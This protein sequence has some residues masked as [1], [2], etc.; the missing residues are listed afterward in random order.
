M[1]FRR[2]ARRAVVWGAL[3]ILLLVGARYAYA[4]F[5]KFGLSSRLAWNSQAPRGVS[6][7]AGHCWLT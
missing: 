3:L 5:G 6:A 4:H 7:L 1:R 2:L